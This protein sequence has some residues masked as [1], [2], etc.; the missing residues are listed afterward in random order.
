MTREPTT[1]KF[2]NKDRKEI[3][4]NTQAPV[5]FFLSRKIYIKPQLY[6]KIRVDSYGEVPAKKRE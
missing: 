6:G 2:V 4:P 3:Q 5:E 1:R